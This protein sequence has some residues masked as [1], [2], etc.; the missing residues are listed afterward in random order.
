MHPNLNILVLNSQVDF[1]N[2]GAHKLA[3]FGRSWFKLEAECM[4]VVEPC[5]R[6]GSVQDF[7]EDD[8]GLAYAKLVAFG[9]YCSKRVREDADLDL[10]GSPGL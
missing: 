1:D 6:C 5:V 10:G 7:P 4:S 9:D 3:T 8:A 2:S